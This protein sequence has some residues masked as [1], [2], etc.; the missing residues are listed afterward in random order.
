MAVSKQQQGSVGKSFANQ[1][2][3]EK[4]IRNL[5]SHRLKAISGTRARQ[6]NTPYRRGSRGAPYLV[7]WIMWDGMGPRIFSIITKCSLFSWVCR[8]QDKAK[9]N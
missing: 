1:L 6:E 5:E 9:G 3:T 4:A 7:R 8:D 2:E